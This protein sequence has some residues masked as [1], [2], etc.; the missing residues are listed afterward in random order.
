MPEL[1]DFRREDVGRV[2]Q[3]RLVERER[4]GHRF[5]H[6]VERADSRFR[7]AIGPCIEHEYVIE[8]NGQLGIVKKSGARQADTAV[9]RDRGHPEITVR[10]LSMSDV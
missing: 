10:V 9:N 6:P 1:M 8:A 3:L 2:L 7:D 5:V 4:E